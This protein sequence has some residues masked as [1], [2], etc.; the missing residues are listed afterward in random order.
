[1]LMAEPVVKLEKKVS[2]A[3]IQQKS[4]VV[5]TGDSKKINK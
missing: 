4:Q 5:G 2:T 3:K 1:M